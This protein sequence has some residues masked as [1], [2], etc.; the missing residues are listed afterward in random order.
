M[1]TKIG[2]IEAHLTK[3]LYT[4]GVCDRSVCMSKCDGT[5]TVC[6]RWGTLIVSKINKG[7]TPNR[8]V[9]EVGLRDASA[10]DVGVPVH[11]SKE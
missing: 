8:R 9:Q 6:T 11:R 4:C 7:S 5:L 1:F 10:D 2:K 3:D